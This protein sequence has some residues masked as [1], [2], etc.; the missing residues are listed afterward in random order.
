MKPRSKPGSEHTAVAIAEEAVELLINA[1]SRILLSYF[2]GTIP[3]IIGGLYFFAELVFNPTAEPLIPVLGAILAMLFMWMRYHQSRFMAQLLRFRA[4]E[5]EPVRHIR[6]ILESLLLHSLI[7]PVGFILL[8]IGLLLIVPFARLSSAFHY[9]SILASGPEPLDSS[10]FKK[11]VRV[12]VIDPGKQLALNWLFNPWFSGAA[13]L[14]VFLILPI[15]VH[16]FEVHEDIYYLLVAL[17]VL[18]AAI[19]SPLGAILYANI[20]VSIYMLPGM[21]LTFFGIETVF[22]RAGAGLFTTLFFMAAWM[23]TFLVM[24]PVMK[25][26]YVVHYFYASSIST[27]EDIL[28]H[29][30]RMARPAGLSVLLLIGLGWGSLA[31]AE[32]PD[33]VS[34][35]TQS[36]YVDA[37]DASLQHEMS[38]PEYL[39]K[40]DRDYSFIPDDATN[41]NALLRFLGKVSDFTSKWLNRL[42]D[43]LRKIW[44]WWHDLIT[45]DAPI[46]S[47]IDLHYSE[48]IRQ[49]EI[50]A[51]ILALASVLLAGLLIKHIR[52]R[53]VSAHVSDSIPEPPVLD[54][55][56]TDSAIAATLPESEWLATAERLT[57]DGDWRGALRAFYFA[58]LACLAAVNLIVLARHK[59]DREYHG[60][61]KR[62][63]HDKPELSEEF[64]GITRTFQMFWYGNRVLSKDGLDAF[65]D[66]QEAVRRHAVS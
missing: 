21:I 43:L 47:K 1:P 6:D 51:L 41:I 20:A 23:L 46:A 16:G 48:G 4:G 10:H 24:D 34:T 38:S 54:L 12:S 5:P 37:L 29:L 30:R 66:V 17:I 52:H 35:T 7:Q 49:S 55:F 59:T 9:Y 62:H 18:V 3:F 27:G 58:T 56:E 32:M 26:I 33:P 11:A 28:M 61:L 53:R 13:F 42:R 64:A 8:A 14:F 50:A 2:L 44:N 36:R 65:R 40:L 31:S 15:L 45:P 22:S 63:A 60:E 39:W 57:L 25:S 19:S